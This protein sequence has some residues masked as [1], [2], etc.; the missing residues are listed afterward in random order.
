VSAPMT[1]AE[2]LFARAAGRPAAAAGDAAVLAADWTLFHDATGPMIL[3][4]LRDAGRLRPARPE[5]VVVVFDHGYPPPS[6]FY[7]NRQRAVREW[8]ESEDGRGVVARTG[9]DGICHQ[10]LFESGLVRPGQ[11]LLGAD[12]HTCTLGAVGAL[13]LGMGATDAAAAVLTG[14]AWLEAPESVRVE[15]MG[16]LGPGVGAKDA[17]LALAGRLLGEDLEG[18][19]LEYGG[20][21]V[22]G[23]D[24]ERRLTL[25]N[26]AVEVG[27]LTA[28]MPY[29]AA[30]A[31]AY[32]PGESAPPDAGARYLLR[33]ELDLSALAPQVAHPHGFERVGPVAEAAGVRVHQAFLGSCTNGR[34][35][36]LREAAAVLKGRR[37]ASGCRLIVIPASREVMRRAAEEG[38]LAELERA[39]AMFEHPN[40]GP[41]LGVHQGALGDGEVCVS[42]SSRNFQ[43]RMGNPQASIYLASAATVAASAAAGR[44]ADPRE[45]LP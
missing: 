20:P 16:A 2:K 23:L 10:V 9:G 13:A 19:V 35:S 12:S 36:D 40:C 11:L 14:K 18:A 28:L 27:A 7:A 44:L 3:K 43:G 41:C 26:M 17:V 38:V 15:L 45:L 32:G 8:L 33:H 5:R 34:L 21:G 6:A 24:L 25:C 22:A 30:A 39:G 31:A 37:V 42:S 1:A 4:I 29:D